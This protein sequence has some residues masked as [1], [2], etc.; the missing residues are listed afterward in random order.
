MLKFRL[1][2]NGVR[3]AH[4]HAS[5]PEDLK[6]KMTGEIQDWYYGKYWVEDNGGQVVFEPITQLS[7]TVYRMIAFVKRSDGSVV[8]RHMFFA[9]QVQ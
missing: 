9:A 7:P 5:S 4:I 8:W 3:V 6:T 2:V 1:L